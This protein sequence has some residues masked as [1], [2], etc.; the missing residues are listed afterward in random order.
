MAGL[1]LTLQTAKSTL[2][3]TQ[4]QIQVTSQNIANAENKSYARQTAVLSTNPPTLTH[5]GWLGTG[6]SVESI[7][8]NRSQF[9]EQRLMAGVSG[10]SHY[11]TLSTQLAIL[12][13]N[14]SDNGSTGI[15]G[16]LGAFWSSW[17]ALV[18]DPQG[19]S[20]QAAVQG[21]AENLKETIRST[22]SN[23]N[24][25]LSSL[26]NS[27]PPGEIQTDVDEANDL[28]KRLADFNRQ[29]MMNE[30]PGR[31]ANDLRDARYQTLRD[32]A[33]V[34]PIQF[35]EESDGSLTISYSGNGST[36]TLVSGV[37]TAANPLQYNAGTGQIT[38]NS[39][40]GAMTMS[41]DTVS[42]GTLG[43]LL[44][45]RDD[46]QGVMDRLNDFT[47]TL[48][49]QVNAAYNPSGAGPNIFQPGGDA[50]NM[51]VVPD[52]FSGQDPA[53]PGL[54]E[55]ALTIAGLQNQT[56]GFPGGV[57]TR[58]SVFLSD[59][60]RQVGSDVQ[61]TK[62]RAS[63]QETLV[64]ELDTQQQ[65]ISGVSLDEEMVEL[66]KHQQIYQAAAKIIQLTLEMLNSILEIS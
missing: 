57:T 64:A 21:A 60:Q 62:I 23:L 55:R 13:A 8:Q 46:I 10:Q 66:M 36:V 2:L 45:A 63:F 53:A 27:M 50:S 30:T 61:D 25:Q 34:M 28:L 5:G 19:L 22:Y 39:F 56:V 52:F 38:L 43:G 1:S 3:N 51:E 59:I 14:I 58:F 33:E 32:L 40:D 48:I 31:T 12:Q 44:E 41:T 37:Q 26:T 7:I 65:S 16:A 18:Q 24:D 11:E 15:S 54:A 9:I 4:V 29:I 6:A 20:E 35:Q 42:G 49:V 47:S 17:D